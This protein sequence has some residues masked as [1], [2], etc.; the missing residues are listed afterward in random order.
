MTKQ[1]EEERIKELENRLS[2]I[3]LGFRHRAR[4]KLRKDI[5]RL[6]LKLQKEKNGN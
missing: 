3:P 1:T 2:Q 6:R 4:G 5:N